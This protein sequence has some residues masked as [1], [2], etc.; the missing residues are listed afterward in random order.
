MLNAQASYQSDVFSLPFSVPGIDSPVIPEDQY[1]VAVDFYQNIFNGGL[2]KSAMEIEKSK[3]KIDQQAI[4]VSLHQTREVINSLFFGILKAQEQINL[5][6]NALRDL[7]NQK[8]ILEASIN[9]GAALPYTVK[10]LE[11][12]IVTLEQQLIEIESSRS[13]LLEMLGKWMEQSLDDDLILEIPETIISEGTLTIARPE[14]HHFGLQIDFLESQKSQLTASRVPDIGLFGTAGF[15]Y[16]NALNPFEVEFTPY[17]LVG[18]K[19][20]WHIFDYGNSSRDKDVIGLQQQKVL[21]AKQNFERTVKIN[22]TKQSREILKY[23]KLIEKDQQIVSLQNEIISVSSSQLQN[24]IITSND[25]VLEVNK[26]L[27]ANISLKMHEI[28]L[29]KTKIELLTLT[30]NTEKI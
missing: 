20:S 6:E 13:I 10:V 15:G 12:E 11:K 22:S 7:N 18:V 4:E 3:V 17:W 28:D 30:G 24:G 9:E 25:Y 26:G 5:V 2:S 27:N 16:P 29:A 14:S 19:L 21:A 8:V 1:K 23:E